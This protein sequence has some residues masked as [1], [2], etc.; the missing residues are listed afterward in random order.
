[1]KKVST[2]LFL[3]I[4]V[5]FNFSACKVDSKKENTKDELYVGTEKSTAPFAISNA[6][7]VINFVAYKTTAKVGVNGWFTKVNVL[8][9]G[10]GN[11]LKE[12]VHHTEFAIPISSLYTKDTSRDYKIRKNF[13][14][15]MDNTDMLSAKLIL[16]D[17]T[18][19]TVEITMNSEIRQVPFTYTIVDKKFSMNAILT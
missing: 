10:E 5:A 2:N 16:S 19:G 3:L 9:G 7:N 13:F 15:L 18:S 12:A 11:S 17:D 1:M 14:G 4:V 8:S 6:E